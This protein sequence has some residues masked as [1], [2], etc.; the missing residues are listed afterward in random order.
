MADVNILL[1]EADPSSA[2]LIATE[3]GRSGLPHTLRVAAGWGQGAAEE[4]PPD[5]V[6]AGTRLAGEEPVDLFRRLRESFPQLPVVAV[7][8]AAATAVLNA[9]GFPYVVDRGDLGGLVPAITQALTE[10]KQ[11]A[12]HRPVAVPLEKVDEQ[13]LRN[14]L[15]ALEKDDPNAEICKL[16]RKELARRS[17]TNGLKSAS[18]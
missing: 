9:A 5:L 2:V 18:P 8:D 1:L 11:A 17:L 12:E 14:F 6:I 10:L 15:A 4:L 3:L 16:Y 13:I 7:A